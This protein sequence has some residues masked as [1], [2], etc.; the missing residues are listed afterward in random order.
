MSSLEA[1]LYIEKLLFEQVEKPKQHK[2]TKIINVFNDNYR[3]NVYIE[4]EE[5]NLTKTR[6]HSSYMCKFKNQQLDIVYPQATGA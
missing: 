2:N 1:E 4:F 5:E 3:V 6:M